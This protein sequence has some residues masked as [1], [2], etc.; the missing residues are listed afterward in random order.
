MGALR[1]RFGRPGIAVA[2]TSLR[3]F[4]LAGALCETNS[5]ER[6]C[7]PGPHSVLIRG[8]QPCASDDNLGGAPAPGIGAHDAHDALVSH[9][10]FGTS[11]RLPESRSLPLSFWVGTHRA[12][13]WR[14]H[15]GTRCHR[16]QSGSARL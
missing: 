4:V 8:A 11:S 1:S 3:A 9:G 16:S 13:T 14:N 7:H 12:P 2:D 10:P 6:G 15:L 5:V